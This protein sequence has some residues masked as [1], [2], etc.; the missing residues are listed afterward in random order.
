MNA[1]DR[2]RELIVD[3]V[4]AWNSGDGRAF[5]A[6][7]TQEAEYVGAD[8]VVRRGRAAIENLLAASDQQRVCIEEI[9]SIDP[10]TDSAK[11]AFRWASQT[12]GHARGGLVHCVMVR[13]EEGWRVDVLHNTGSA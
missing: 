1:G 10:R 7:F 4:A 13:Q 2:I 9:V 6:L 12:R 11:A 8:G 5:G 3:L